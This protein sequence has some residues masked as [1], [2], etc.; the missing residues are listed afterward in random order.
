MISGETCREGRY[1][2]CRNW[3]NS[4]PWNRTQ[5]V[6]NTDATFQSGTMWPRP[7]RDC[8]ICFY[9]KLQMYRNGSLTHPLEMNHF[10]CQCTLGQGLKST[11]LQ[12]SRKASS[13]SAS[14]EFSVITHTYQD[15]LCIG[16]VEGWFERSQETCWE[17]VFVNEVWKSD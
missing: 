10:Q 12:Q 17:N 9:N 13:D 3:I 6:L 14:H 2:C 7:Y 11:G 16:Q 1:S 8:K 5:T 15:S 4:G